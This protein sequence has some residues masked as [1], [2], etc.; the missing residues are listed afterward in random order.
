MSP[1]I[2]IRH[3]R[4]FLAVADTENFTRAAERLGVTQ[5]SISQ[6]IRDLETELGTTLF[7]RLGKRVRM[8]DAGVAF[9]QR[10]DVVMRKLEEACAS[11]T[12]VPGQMSGHLDVGVIPALHLSAIPPVLARFA[13]EFPSVT[14]AVHERASRF[15][16]TEVEA[17]RFDFGF[18]L[19]SNKSPNLRCETILSEE[20]ALIVR[21]DHPYANK[22]EI[23]I[24]DLEKQPISVLPESFDMR[25]LVEGVF[26]RVK[27]R[28][29]IAFE[30]STIDSALHTVVWSGIPTILPPIV[31]KGREALNLTAVRLSG[32]NRKIDFGLIFARG[33]K[34]IPAVN[35]FVLALRAVMVPSAPS[36][37]KVGTKS[38]RD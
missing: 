34:P 29:K 20:L 24:R 30:I 23:L 6:Q 35:E 9:R 13:K 14:V 3:L 5:P 12:H 16:E 25:Q 7:Q 27:L 31:L 19:M 26:E 10:A 4:Y 17:G 21:K 8:T 18:G 15:I 2:E 11:V 32:S 38:R 28:P 37:A 1:E 33:S 22:A 36:A